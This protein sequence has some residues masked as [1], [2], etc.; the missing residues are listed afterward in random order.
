MKAIFIITIVVPVRT[1]Y[2][3]GMYV[4]SY[5]RTTYMRIVPLEYERRGPGVKIYKKI[6]TKSKI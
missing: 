2:V 6:Q 1:R 3:P 5:D 4:R